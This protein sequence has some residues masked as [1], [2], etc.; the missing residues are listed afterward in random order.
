MNHHSLCCIVLIILSVFENATIEATPQ[1]DVG[2]SVLNLGGFDQPNPYRQGSINE[3]LALRPSNLNQN[4][5]P[6]VPQQFYPP[7]IP[8]RKINM[9]RPLYVVNNYEQN[10]NDNAA[11]VV[12]HGKPPYNTYGGYFCGNQKPPRPIQQ[13]IYNNNPFWS[14]FSN[15][16]NGV[17]GPNTNVAAAVTTGSGMK[18][19][20]EDNDHNK[21][22]N[23]VRI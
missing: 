7:R 16:F 14:H 5:K 8:Y 12:N 23:E 22:P 1:F 10:I 11:P 18:P 13:P 2:R 3:F 17:V 9:L 15:V 4:D 20:H 21:N 6:C 19:T